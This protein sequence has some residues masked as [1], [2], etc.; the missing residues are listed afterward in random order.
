[1]GRVADSYPL[2][3]G[4][5]P[6]KI[7]FLDTIMYERGATRGGGTPI[8]ASGGGTPIEGSIGCFPNEGEQGQ[9]LSERHC[10][11]QLQPR[12]RVGIGKE[13]CRLFSERGGAGANAFGTAL[14][15]PAQ[16]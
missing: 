14:C 2:V 6:G 1:V 11:C 13:G 4:S 8:E 12:V 5:N 10:V 7:L 3:P 9:M 15:V 16:A